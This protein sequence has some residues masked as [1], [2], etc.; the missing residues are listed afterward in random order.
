VNRSADH[1]GMTT[2]GLATALIVGVLLGAVGHLVGPRGRVPW[3]VTVCVGT[4][5]V[6]LGTI[7]AAT[8][9]RVPPEHHDRTV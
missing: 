6:L 3:W 9:D 4:G 8:A 1:E 7:V 5:A 2:T